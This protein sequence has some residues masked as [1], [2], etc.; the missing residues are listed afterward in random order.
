MKC[1]YYIDNLDA[2]ACPVKL[3][4]FPKC[5]GEM[6]LCLVSLKDLEMYKSL[7]CQFTG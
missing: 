2:K 3:E 6:E 5:K 7:K 4:A 1:P